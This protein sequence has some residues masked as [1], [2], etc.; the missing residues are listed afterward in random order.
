[1]TRNTAGILTISL[2]AAAANYRQLAAKSAPAQTAAAVKADAYGLGMARL[3]PALAAAGCDFFYTA[4]LDEALALRACLPEAAIA[5][6]HG[7]G[8]ADYPLAA[9]HNLLPVLCDLGAIQGWHTLAKALDQTLPAIIHLDTGMNRLGLPADE[10]ARLIADQTPLH[11]L[12]IRYW[13]S[14]LACADEPA[15]PLNAEQLGLFR[16][17]RAALPPAPASFANSSGIF[18]GPAYH[19]SQTRP[20]CALYGINP[21]PAHPNPMRPVATLRAPVLQHRP[22]LP[23]APVGYGASWRSKRLGKLA[24][25]PVGYA[26]GFIR[27]LG[28][29]GMV[30]FGP[31][32]APV[33]GRVSMDLI[34]VDV[35][36]VPEALCQPGMMAELF[37]TRQSVDAVAAAAGTIGY[38]IL[39]NLGSRYRRVYEGEENGDKSTRAAGGHGS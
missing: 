17:Y 25:L 22:L 10:T 13:L 34:T 3:A 15:H 28:D 39:T 8:T 29:R 12:A 21:V 5:V 7:I 23:G 32:A 35:T 2:A 20:G 19:F 36:D 14:H 11:N 24:V 16:R 31:H 27:S 30:H 4:H 37:G 33:V 38:E 9:R 6:L 18:L 26:D 1:M